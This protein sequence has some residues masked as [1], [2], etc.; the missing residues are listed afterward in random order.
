MLDILVEF[1]KNAVLTD[2]I[3]SVLTY[4]S[5]LPEFIQFIANKDSYSIAFWRSLYVFEDDLNAQVT[6]LTILDQIIDSTY[7]KEVNIS[8]ELRNCVERSL[9][10]RYQFN[11]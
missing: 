10:E 9:N 11:M 4:L 6:I 7:I 2:F 1:N 5:D 3:F 8:A